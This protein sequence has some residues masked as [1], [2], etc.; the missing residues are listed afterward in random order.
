M[1]RYLAAIQHQKVL[2]PTYSDQL[3]D[4]TLNDGIGG[5]SAVGWD[6]PQAWSGPS[7][8]FVPLDKRGGRPGPGE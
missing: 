8:N 3:L 4:N 6:A 2:G 5:R 1:L 7:G